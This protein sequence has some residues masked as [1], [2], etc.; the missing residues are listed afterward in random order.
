ML[1]FADSEPESE[2]YLTKDGRESLVVWDGENYKIQQH[3]TDEH[4]TLYYAF[5]LEDLYRRGWRYARPRYFN[6]KQVHE[7]LQALREEL[8]AK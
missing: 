3:V 5:D 2:H 8:V 6:A 4:M 7:L 1:P